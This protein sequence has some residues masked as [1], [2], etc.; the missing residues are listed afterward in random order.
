MEK[1]RQSSHLTR[2]HE[3]VPASNMPD[4]SPGAI[5]GATN[6]APEVTL[7]Q[8]EGPQDG[9]PPRQVQKPISREAGHSADA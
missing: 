6:L 3:N 2:V 9:C 8:T 7:S 1:F 5:I 4:R